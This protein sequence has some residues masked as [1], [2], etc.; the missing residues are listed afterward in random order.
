MHF[1]K[2]E[3]GDLSNVC[4]NPKGLRQDTCMALT[5]KSNWHHIYLI[6]F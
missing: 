2:F 4:D 1:L 6:Q 3:N 5:Y